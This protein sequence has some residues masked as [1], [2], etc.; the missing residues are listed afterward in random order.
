M[1][2]CLNRIESSDRYDQDNNKSGL[3][4]ND[5]DYEAKTVG[6]I[7]TLMDENGN[8]YISSSTH[9]SIDIVT[10][11]YL[12]TIISLRNNRSNLFSFRD[13]SKICQNYLSFLWNE[14]WDNLLCG[15]GIV[16]NNDTMTAEFDI[17]KYGLNKNKSYAD[18]DY[19]S[20]GWYTVFGKNEI[21]FNNMDENNKYHWSFE[22]IHASGSNNGQEIHIGIIGKTAQ[23]WKSME[24]KNMLKVA[25]KF[26]YS[27]ETIHCIYC[28]KCAL[29]STPNPKSYGNY[30]ADIDI[31]KM[32]A[33]VYDSSAENVR[34]KTPLQFANIGDTFDIYMDC[35]KGTVQFGVNGTVYDVVW[36]GLRDHLDLR[37]R[38]VC[39]M[40]DGRSVRIKHFSTDYKVIS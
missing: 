25:N 29:F 33:A 31:R 38:I 4:Q 10:T 24:L 13:L 12:R 8:Q 40:I 11:G 32:V 18:P 3:R 15:P 22:I 34:S 36:N 21:D 35:R 30:L 16:I 19:I 9:G 7:R 17:S 23:E 6:I 39:S 28:G 14:C 2:T 1:G 37:Y 5:D 20:T 26:H 27:Q